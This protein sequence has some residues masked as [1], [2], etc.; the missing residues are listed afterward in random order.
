MVIVA[1]GRQ[2]DDPPLG[3]AASP[4]KPRQSCCWRREGPPMVGRRITPHRALS[5]GTR[6]EDRGTTG[7]GYPADCEAVGGRKPGAALA[8]ASST[9]SGESP[10]KAKG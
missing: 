5:R 8:G 1:F 7:P 10:S 3:R 4:P 2:R 9:G 6:D